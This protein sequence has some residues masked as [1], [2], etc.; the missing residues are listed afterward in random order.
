MFETKYVP[1]Q[2]PCGV[3]AISTAFD[4]YLKLFFHERNAPRVM[5]ALFKGNNVY[6]YYPVN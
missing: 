2:K 6:F 1:C 3:P 5:L 4:M